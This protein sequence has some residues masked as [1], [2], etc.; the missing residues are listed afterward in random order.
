MSDGSDDLPK[1]VLLHNQTQGYQFD[2]LLL[3]SL[4]E[5]SRGFSSRSRGLWR[6]SAQLPTTEV[7]F[8]QA[9]LGE[10]SE[11]AELLAQSDLEGVTWPGSPPQ[12]PAPGSLEPQPPRASS[13]L[14]GF[15]LG[16]PFGFSQ[17]P[18]EASSLLSL[19]DQ[20]V[21]PEPSLVDH[22]WSLPSFVDH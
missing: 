20:A 16:L 17:V 7:S 1:Q 10:I 21:G 5:T 22:L 9:E 19:V 15:R 3:A 8:F 18:K 11:P 12:P 2:K 13:F 6:S 4:S 14:I